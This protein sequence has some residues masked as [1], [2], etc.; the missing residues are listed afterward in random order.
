MEGAMMARNLAAQKFRKEFSFMHLRDFDAEVWSL[1]RKRSQI[2][3]REPSAPLLGMDMHGGVLESARFN[4]LKAGFG[5]IKWEKRNFFHWKPAGPPGVIIMNPPYDERISLGNAIEFYQRIG[6]HL[7]QE[8]G[9]WKAWIISS[10]LQAVKR[11][12]LK[13]IRRI[14]VFNGPL[15]CRFIGFDL[16]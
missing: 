11:V 6:D 13:P 3:E 5:E 16:Y 1:V 7:K 8:C 12:G 15:D 2:S 10:H 14:P 4:A 9:G